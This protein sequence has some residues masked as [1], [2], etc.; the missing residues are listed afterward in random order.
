[1][2]RT[3]L[4]LLGLFAFTAACSSSTTQPSQAAPNTFIF[5]ATLLPSNEVPAIS[6]AESVARGTAT[7]TFVVTRDSA[8]AIT[9]ATVTYSVSLTAFP[10]GSNI[11][12][13]H[14][15]EGASGVAGPVRIQTTL[16][17]GEVVFTG[18]AGSFTKST[19]SD[20]AFAQSVISTP[21]NFYFNVHSTLNP[22]GVM[23]GQLVSAN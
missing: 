11:T 13:A 9:A 1:M 4:L 21:G 18:G 23:R 10:A 5:T 16:S 7:I 14:I 12:N 2:T 20:A 8:N 15:H 3:T 6:N 19:A 22:G 17:S